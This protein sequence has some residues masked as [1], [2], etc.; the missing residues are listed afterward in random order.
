MTNG[1]QEYSTDEQDLTSS[2]KCEDV[3]RQP[4]Y[5]ALACCISGYTTLHYDTSKQRQALRSHPVS[6]IRPVTNGNENH[7]YKSDTGIYLHPNS[8]ELNLDMQS[9]GKGIDVLPGCGSL[10]SPRHMLRMSVTSESR[11]N[12]TSS[13]ISENYSSFSGTNSS[14]TSSHYS[15]H[16]FSTTSS[17][18]TTSN[19]YTREVTSNSHSSSS[20]S[21]EMTNGGSRLIAATKAPGQVSPSSFIVQ[22]VERLYGPGALAQGFYS[23]R[24]ISTVSKDCKGSPLSNGCDRTDSSDSLPVLKLLRPE[25]RAQLTVASRK[26]KGPSDQKASIDSDDNHKESIESLQ[27]EEI[28]KPVENDEVDA[29]LAAKTTNIVLEEIRDGQ[30]YLKLLEEKVRELEALAQRA[31]DDLPGCPNDEGCGMLRAAS[32]KAR[33]LIAEKLNQFRGLCH[34]NLKQSEKDDFPTTNEDLAGFWDMVL[35]QIKEILAQFE[36]LEKAKNN[37]WKIDDPV[38]KRTKDSGS[39]RAASAPQRKTGGTVIRKPAS[40]NS[41]ESNKANSELRKAR[42]E[43]RRKLIEEKRKAMKNLKKEDDGDRKSVV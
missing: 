26:S 19:T 33:L 41:S 40:A 31:E 38:E 18:S 24:R 35:L 5:V 22:R 37:D 27:A 32:G 21:S 2:P 11:R 8:N 15:S 3:G 20:Y 28:T 23:P 12:F 1:N 13:M 25:F 6:P 10:N 34:N 16:H 39:T 4:S 9:E 36:E 17:S 42:D 29:T 43:A 14:A 30:Y 7:I